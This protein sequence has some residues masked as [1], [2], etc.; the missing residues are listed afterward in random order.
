M[1]E[2]E[3]AEDEDLVLPRGRSVWITVGE[4]SLKIRHHENG[5]MDMRAWAKGQEDDDPLD[6]IELDASEKDAEFG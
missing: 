4:R 1:A 6:G 5:T 2:R 3:I